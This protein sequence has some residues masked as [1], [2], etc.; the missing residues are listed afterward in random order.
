MPT[1]SYVC[2]FSPYLPATCRWESNLILSILFLTWCFVYV[3]RKSVGCIINGACEPKKKVLT[4]SPVVGLA[5]GEERNSQ[6]GYSNHLVTVGL[7][8]CPV[9]HHLLKLFRLWVFQTCTWLLDYLFREC[10]MPLPQHLW[11]L[12]THITIPT[13]SSHQA[14]REAKMVL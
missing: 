4:R 2:I 8:K 3:I 11:E 5:E 13:Q 6:R 1:Q 14:S 10:L 7:L 9:F 12:V